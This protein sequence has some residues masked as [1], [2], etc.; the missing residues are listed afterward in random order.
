MKYIV[1]TESQT[2][3]YP[4]VILKHRTLS[5]AMDSATYQMKLNPKL[6]PKIYQGVLKGV[7]YRRD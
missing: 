4:S 7:G 5:G 3:G 6:R 2:G 1:V